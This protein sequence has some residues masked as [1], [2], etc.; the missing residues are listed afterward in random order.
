MDVVRAEPLTVLKH[1][2]V[3][4]LMREYLE[5]ATLEPDSDADNAAYERCWGALDAFLV[6]K[7][8]VDPEP[9]ALN[10]TNGTGQK[11]CVAFGCGCVF[12]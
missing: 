1:Q 6:G 3:V 8:V 11:V 5:L 4:Q 7:V 2:K 12:V 9:L 10:L